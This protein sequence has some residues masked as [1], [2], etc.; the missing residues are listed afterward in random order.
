MTARSASRL[1]PF[2]L[3]A[4]APAGPGVRVD[5]IGYEPGGPK[6][7]I[8]SDL[9]AAITAIVTTCGEHGPPPPSR[10]R[11]GPPPRSGEEL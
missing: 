5:Q 2:M 11:D 1:L 10:K 6:I 3:I 8:L 7:A 9:E 4:A